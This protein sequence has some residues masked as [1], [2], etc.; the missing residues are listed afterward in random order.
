MSDKQPASEDLKTTA[1]EDAGKQAAAVTG[2]TQRVTE[3]GTSEDKEAGDRR[4]VKK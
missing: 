3:G 1:R 2:S 4:F